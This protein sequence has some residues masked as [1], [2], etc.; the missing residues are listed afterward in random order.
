MGPLLEIWVDGGAVITLLSKCLNATASIVYFSVSCKNTGLTDHFHFQSNRDACMSVNACM[1]MSV[2]AYLSPYCCQDNAIKCYHESNIICLLPLWQMRTCKLF[3]VLICFDFLISIFCF[4]PFGCLIFI[5]L[6][7]RIY[8][9]S[10]YADI[11][12]IMS[13]FTP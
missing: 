9:T 10:I 5:A 4:S 11:Y 1:Q 7:C 6:F 8:R 13:W 3:N 12:N 2:W